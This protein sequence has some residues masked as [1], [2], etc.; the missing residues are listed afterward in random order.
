MRS[1]HAA[2]CDDH[3]PEANCALQ[4]TIDS[5]MR[6]R[7][8]HT[9]ATAAHWGAAPA[10]AAAAAAAAATAAG[11]RLLLLLLLSLTLLLLTIAPGRR[12]R[13]I[14][15]AACRAPPAAARA[16]SH[17]QS[18]A[19]QSLSWHACVAL[20]VHRIA[21]GGTPAA[22]T[23]WSDGCMQSHR[24][25]TFALSCRHAPVSSPPPLR[26]HL[27]LGCRHCRLC[28]PLQGCRRRCGGAALTGTAAAMAWGVREPARVPPLQ[29]APRSEPRGQP[30]TR[31]SPAAVH[32]AALRSVPAL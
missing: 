27:A 32:L 3:V 31:A 19:Q 12:L 8:G 2:G 29:P 14:A 20:P 10:S 21:S 18:S 22:A 9:I 23:G 17:L 7:V 30:M 1:A 6:S 4:C 25:L 15:V 28:C 16:C 13:R 26:L 5:G 11:H 24:E